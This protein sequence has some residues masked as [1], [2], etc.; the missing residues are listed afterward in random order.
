[1]QHVDQGCELRREAAVQHFPAGRHFLRSELHGA[2]ADRRPQPTE[3]HFARGVVQDTRHLVHKIVA[4]RAIALPV[5]SEFLARAK[6]FLDDDIKLAPRDVLRA[7]VGE[8]SQAHA[9]SPAIL[10]GISQAVD[11]VDAYAVDQAVCKKLKQL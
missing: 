6:D 9:Q 7:G 3:R 5:R 8:R 10:L 2:P 4:T 1:M 11:V